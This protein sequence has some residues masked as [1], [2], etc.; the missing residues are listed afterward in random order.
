MQNL[1]AANSHI[2]FQAQTTKSGDC[3]QHWFDIA[4]P[5]VGAQVEIETP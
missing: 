3:F 1:K 5:G 2:S 4:P